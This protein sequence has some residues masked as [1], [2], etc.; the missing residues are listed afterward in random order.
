MNANAPTRVNNLLR[1]H[2]DRRGKPKVKRT[3]DEAYRLANEQH[4]N[5]YRCN[6]CNGWHIGA[7]R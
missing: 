6:F 3:R 1:N 2:F 5:A 7:K 4:M